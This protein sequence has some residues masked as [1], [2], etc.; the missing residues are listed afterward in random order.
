MIGRDG[1]RVDAAVMD[2]FWSQ[3]GMGLTVTAA[4]RVV[5]I[6][7]MT[8]RRA[9]RL[10]GGVRPRR[11]VVSAGRFLSV[12][13]R[14]QIALG[15]AAGCSRAV[16]ARQLGRH[17]ATIG[18]ELTRN[19]TF[20]R[21]LVP[22]MRD[23]LSYVA[24]TADNSARVRARR[25]KAAKLR[26]R[27]ELREFVQDGL[28]QKWSPRQIES[29]L[30][31]EFPDRPEMRV[32]HETIYQSLY[33]QSRGALRRELTACLRTGRAIRRPKRRAE[34]RRGRIKDMVMISER[35]AQVADRAV[36]GHWEGDLIIGKNTQSAIGTL[37]ERTTRYVMLLH[38][39][40]GHG[41]N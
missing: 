19:Q 29:R 36:P 33:V 17:P 15:W 14:E 10:S 37:V 25:P 16:I 13:E 38:L 40:N 34:E 20:S 28:L 30:E 8:G 6:D 32:S 1:G 11:P 2:A 22:V 7:V 27:G 4:A 3:R 24:S 21:R 12:L 31:F 35:P 9:V 18:R 23:G 39:P 26:E 5:G 41:A